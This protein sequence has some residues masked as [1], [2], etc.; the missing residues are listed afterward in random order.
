MRVQ[1][2]GSFQTRDTAVLQHLGALHAWGE[3][4]AEKRLHLSRDA[5]LTVLLLRVWNL[6]EPL[7]L[8]QSGDYWGCFSW[9]ALTLV[10]LATFILSPASCVA[11]A[12]CAC[13]H[14]VS[15]AWQRRF[16]H[17][18]ANDCVPVRPS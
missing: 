12:S 5:V 3:G 7:A 6:R 13:V 9:G 15:C 11:D 14:P 16:H 2:E 4:F 8:Q 10:T 18:R 1:L 17:E